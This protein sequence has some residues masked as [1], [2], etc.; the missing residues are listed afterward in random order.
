MITKTLAIELKRANS[1]MICVGL[2]PGIVA[3]QLSAPFF[4]RVDPKKLF[5]PEEA[6]PKLLAVVEK[7]TPEE[8]GKSSLMMARRSPGEPGYPADTDRG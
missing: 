7:L 1:Q 5:S 2:H 4:S 6:A 8:T 3:T